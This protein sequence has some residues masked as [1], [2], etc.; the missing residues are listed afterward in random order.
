MASDEI[1]WQ[2]VNNQHCS[3]KLKYAVRLDSVQL[4]DG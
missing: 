3:F 2:I 4:A 1:V